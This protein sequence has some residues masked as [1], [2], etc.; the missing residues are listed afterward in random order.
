MKSSLT[1]SLLR[2]FTYAIILLF[3]IRFQWFN[4]DP[5]TKDC[6]V[7]TGRYLCQKEK[8]ADVDAINMTWRW[9]G[10]FTFGIVTWIL[11]II[12]IAENHFCANKFIN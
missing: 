3:F 10:L 4:P 8:S 1:W 7:E 9:K 12:S 6:W 11:A 2:A 5:A